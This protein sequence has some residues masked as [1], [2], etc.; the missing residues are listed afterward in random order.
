MTPV[1]V[2]LGSNVD[3]ERRVR[4]AVTL[5]REHFGHLRLSPVYRN[6]AVGFSGADFLNLVTAFDTALPLTGLIPALSDIETRC[7][8]ERG[9]QRFAPR[10]MDIDLLLYGDI[11]S[12]TPVKL[13]RPDILRYPFVLKPLTDLMGEARHLVTGRRYA[14]HW[15]EMAEAGGGLTPVMLAGL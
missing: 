4:M 14:E 5:L 13:P 9:A 2:A 12:E 11:V 3:A 8:R 15:A 7:G 10:S 1:C 6:P